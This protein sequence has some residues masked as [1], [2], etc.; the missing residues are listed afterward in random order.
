MRWT[1]LSTLLMYLDVMHLLDHKAI[2]VG[3]IR[4]YELSVSVNNESTI[5]IVRFADRPRFPDQLAIG[6]CA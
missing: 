3:F 4:L 6:R 2:A 5:S 1:E